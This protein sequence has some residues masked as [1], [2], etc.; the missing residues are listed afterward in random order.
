[1]NR[2]LFS[3]LAI[4][5][6]ITN[7]YATNDSITTT[8]GYSMDV[9][10][11]LKNGVAKSEPRSNWDIAFATNKMSSSIL[12]ND[13]SGVVLYTYPKG[14]TS[15]WT[16]VDT[17]GLSTWTVMYNS[18]E[19]WEEGAFGVN[20]IGHPDYGWCVYNM[21]THNL[22]G[23]SIF[24][25]KTKDDS[26]LKLWMI[27]KES[28]AG[29]YHFRFA[30]LDGTSDTTVDL[31]AST[32][33]TKNF[34][35][36]DLTNKQLLDREPDTD[37]W[38]ILY[39]KYQAVQPSGGYYA[40]T[41]VLSNIGVNIAKA[42][43]VDTTFTDWPN[44]P[45]STDKAVIGWDWKE[46]SMTTFS[47]EVSDSLVYFIQNNDGDI[48]KLIY[49]GF[50]GSTSGNVYFTKQLL[51]ATN[52]SESDNYSNI[53]VFPNPATSFIQLDIDGD[54]SQSSVLILDIAGKV[55]LNQRIDSNHEVI[56][57]DNLPSGLYFVKIQ[58]KKQ[59]KVF[60]III[61]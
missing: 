14:D 2:I 27:G 15:A 35:Y 13:G 30:K 10:Y 49:T 34:V 20:A 8:P 40:V 25:I 50:S 52:I 58:D 3:I 6:S 37:S 31:N 4:V 17:S 38:D 11:S 1:M 53:K 42:E 46:F 55:V 60:K 26:Y 16:S 5:I 29:I 39:T 51:S 22:T 48:Y 57:I 44:T 47:Y 12:I 18:E 61:Q 43:M 54:I 36:Y 9:F 41:G 45:F 24:I 21:V 28:M 56:D 33:S 23:D 59:S 19:D 32:Y 7:I